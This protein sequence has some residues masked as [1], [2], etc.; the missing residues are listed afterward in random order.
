LVVEHQQGEEY[1]LVRATER[2][3]FPVPD[4]L[5]RPE[6]AQIHVIGREPSTKP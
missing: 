5:E 3:S 4:D 1:P 6:D 2:L